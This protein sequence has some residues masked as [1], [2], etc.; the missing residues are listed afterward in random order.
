MSILIEKGQRVP[1]VEPEF[2][3]TFQVSLNFDAPTL[4]LDFSCFGLDAAGKLSDDRYM[5][6]YNQTESP[7]QAIQLKD[8]ATG[9]A[10]FGLDLTKVPDTIDKLVF[11]AT[12]DGTGNMQAL[13]KGQINIGSIT[14]SMKGSD[15]SQEKAI[16]VADIYRKG[17]IWRLAANGQGFNGGLSALLAHFGGTEATS[18]ASQSDTPLAGA[19]LIASNKLSLDKKIEQHAPHLI[20]LVKKAQVSLD[21]KGMGQHKARCALCLDISASMSGLYAS[22][23]VQELCDRVLALAT[24]FD[25][26]GMLDVFLFGESGYQPAPMQIESCGAYVQDLLKRY[27]LEYDTQYHTA[28]KLIREHYFGGSGANSTPTRASEP[29]YVMFITDGD[30]SYKEQTITQMKW[31]SHEPIFWQFMGVGHS[32]F[33]LLEKLDNLSG[34]F[35][36][37]ADFFAVKNLK[38][39]SDDQLFDKMMEEYPEW[40]KTAK[41]K[42]LL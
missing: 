25:D 29:V 1:L 22:N 41:Q 5:V 15:F 11:T 23:Q 27:P 8:T 40:V 12:I 20:S 39:V 21:K 33:S 3:N 31:A 19:P 17:G 18:V 2:K 16:M 4:S 42:G 30:T 37:N 6:F 14:F 36:D 28:I 10:N 38:S 32:N 26:D 34:R 9:V 7:E 35:I 13:V 24:R